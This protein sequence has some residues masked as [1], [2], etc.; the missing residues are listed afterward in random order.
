MLGKAVK[1]RHCP[2]TVSA[3]ASPPVLIECRREMQDFGWGPSLY[4][5]IDSGN[6]WRRERLM[7]SSP[8]R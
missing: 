6:H 5:G 4:L 1:V 7:V 2:A 8:G 3:P